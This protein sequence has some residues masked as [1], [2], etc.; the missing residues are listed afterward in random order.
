M[1]TAESLESENERT[2][3]LDCNNLEPKNSKLKTGT[4]T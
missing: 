3:N 1:I 2:D 4:W